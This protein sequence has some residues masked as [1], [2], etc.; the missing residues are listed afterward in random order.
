VRSSRLLDRPFCRRHRRPSRGS[1]RG[2]IPSSSS[3]VWS[4]SLTAHTGTVAW[5]PHG[6]IADAR[7]MPDPPLLGFL[8]S[9]DRALSFCGPEP[10]RGDRHG[11]L[12]SGQGTMSE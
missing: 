8:R 2:V 9:G 6:P 4:W 5:A 7:P 1:A 10:I 11:R 12:A 3:G